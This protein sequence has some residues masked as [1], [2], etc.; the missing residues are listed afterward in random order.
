VE[1][2]SDSDRWGPG[3]GFCA[4]C[5]PACCVSV[6]LLLLW[7]RA[8]PARAAVLG[9]S[10]DELELSDELVLELSEVTAKR[11]GSSSESEV[12]AKGD[13]SSSAFRKSRT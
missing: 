6:C 10:S 13:G 11:G 2:S 12:S 9:D 4:L 3:R 7:D 8:R 5:L 1:G